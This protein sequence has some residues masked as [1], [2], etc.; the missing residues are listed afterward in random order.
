MLKFFTGSLETLNHPSIRDD[1]IKFHEKFYSA[2]RMK[3]VVCSDE[4]IETLE[5]WVKEIFS[6]IPN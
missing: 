5:K 4:S 6:K 1:V 3:L 2:N